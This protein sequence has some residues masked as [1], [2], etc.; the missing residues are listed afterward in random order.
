ILLDKLHF[1]RLRISIN[2]IQGSEE[3]LAA[4]ATRNELRNSLR[5]ASEMSPSSLCLGMINV[6]KGKEKVEIEFSMPID[7]LSLL[8]LRYR[9][10]VR[11]RVGHK[12]FSVLSHKEICVECLRSQVS[13]WSLEVIF[14]RG[15][16]NCVVDYGCKVVDL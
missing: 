15:M 4:C 14:V 11:V 1:N 9:L 6:K 12:V 5:A 7:C 2:K 13:I 16:I 10:P 8:K 3:S